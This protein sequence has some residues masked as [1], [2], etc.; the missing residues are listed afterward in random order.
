MIREQA[1]RTPKGQWVRVI[2][3]WSPYQFNEKRMPTVR[4]LNEAA[5]DTP[6]FVLFLYSQGMINR[7]AVQALGW[8]LRQGKRI[9]MPNT[10]SP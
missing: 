9:Q 7:A 3:G 5:S 4:E 1:Q 2:G 10:V 8:P 6:T